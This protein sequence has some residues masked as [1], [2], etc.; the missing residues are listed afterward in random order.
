M[1]RIHIHALNLPFNIDMNRRV[2]FVVGYVLRTG[3]LAIVRYDWFK[4]ID[5]LVCLITFSTAWFLYVVGWYCVMTVNGELEEI[6]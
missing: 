5:F 4:C 6:W 3:I 1:D 2:T